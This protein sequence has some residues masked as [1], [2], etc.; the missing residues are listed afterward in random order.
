MIRWWASAVEWSLSMASVA[1]WTAVWKP[2]VTWVASRSLSMVLGT[3]ITF[4]PFTAS[5]L[6]MRS[7][8][9]PPTAIRQ[10]MRRRFILAITSSER[11]TMRTPPSGCF[12]G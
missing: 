7:D 12:S 1:V 10:S 3:P 5:S 8:P 9:S 4:R 2:K 11:S 6:A